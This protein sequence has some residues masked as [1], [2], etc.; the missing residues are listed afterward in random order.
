MER[1]AERKFVTLILLGV[2]LASVAAKSKEPVCLKTPGGLT[3]AIKRLADCELIP[4]EFQGT[5]ERVSPTCHV[6]HCVD[7]LEHQRQLTRKAPNPRTHYY[8]RSIHREHLS[9]RVPRGD[10][11]RP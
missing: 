10:V 2:L 3:C 1:P 6:T 8:A 4:V 11:H 5:P 7:S 9:K